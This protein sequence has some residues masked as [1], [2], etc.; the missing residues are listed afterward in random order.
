MP[1]WE[2]QQLWEHTKKIRIVE[3]RKEEK[4]VL[5]I[6]DHRE[7]DDKYEFVRRRRRSKSPSLLMYLAG[8]RP[9]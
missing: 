8:G 3:K 7:E 2:Q 1:E 4:V 5:K 6:K 9:A